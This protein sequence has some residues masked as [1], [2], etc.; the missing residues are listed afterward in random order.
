MMLHSFDYCV[1]YRPPEDTFLVRVSACPACIPSL[2]SSHPKLS[3]LPPIEVLLPA[4]GMA[5]TLD[6]SS[7]PGIK[8]P[9]YTSSSLNKE[10]RMGQDQGHF[11]EVLLSGWT[12]IKDTSPPQGPLAGWTRIRDTSPRSS[13][14][15]SVG[16]P[17]AQN[18]SVAHFFTTLLGVL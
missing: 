15:G 11:P 17:G 5:R 10:Q 8:I 13:S 3:H 18:Y 16:S 2:S 9:S 6:T 12:R 4:D 1:E 7:S 14:L